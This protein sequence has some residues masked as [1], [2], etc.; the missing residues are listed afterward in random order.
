MS[1]RVSSTAVNQSHRVR[2]QPCLPTSLSDDSEGHLVYKDGD[3]LQ[4][5]CISSN[6]SLCYRTSAL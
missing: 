2:W 5:R 3:I 6:F 1:L 4:S